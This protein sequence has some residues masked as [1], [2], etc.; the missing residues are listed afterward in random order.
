[1]LIDLTMIDEEANCVCTMWAYLFILLFLVFDKVLHPQGICRPA[2]HDHQWH[3]G[4]RKPASALGRRHNKWNA[5]PS[6]CAVR[7]A[8]GMIPPEQKR[9]KKRVVKFNRPLAP[10]SFPPLPTQSS[11]PSSPLTPGPRLS[12]LQLPF[13]PRTIRGT[14]TDTVPT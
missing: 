7:K 2:V 10:P 3:K 11:S 14:L 4:K 6:A 1:M 8:R 5:L 12:H 9:Y 13:P